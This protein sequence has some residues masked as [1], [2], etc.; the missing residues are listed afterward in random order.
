VDMLGGETPYGRLVVSGWEIRINP[1]G[2]AQASAGELEL[3]ESSMPDSPGQAD[4]S[5]GSSNSPTMNVEFLP[6]R[7]CQP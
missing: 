6:R 1:P 5:G 4:S 3:I 7:R 2:V